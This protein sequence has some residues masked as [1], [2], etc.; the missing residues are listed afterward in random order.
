MHSSAFLLVV[1]G[2]EPH[3]SAA[4]STC[5]GRREQRG[6]RR[7]GARAHRRRVRRCSSG[8]S[9]ESVRSQPGVSRSQ[10]EPANGVPMNEHAPGSPGRS[11]CVFIVHLLSSRWLS[12]LAVVLLTMTTVA[13]HRRGDATEFP[14]PGRTVGRVPVPVPLELVLSGRDLTEPRLSPDGESVAFVHRWGAGTAIS[15][16]DAEGRGPERLVTFGPEP[17][18]GRGLGRRVLHLDAELHGDRVRGARRR[19]LAGGRDRT[20]SGDLARTGMSGPCCRPSGDI[21]RLRPRRARDLGD[22]P[23]QRAVAPSR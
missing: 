20:S 4:R 8:V 9:P 13:H 3:V 6:T 17:A 14:M 16:V 18:P 23:A 2:V 15:V 22:P 10:A 5:I 12:S 1:V 11:F 7:R 21:R 19:T